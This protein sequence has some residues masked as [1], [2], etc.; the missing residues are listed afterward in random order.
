MRG[1][2][3]WPRRLCGGAFRFVPYL[4]PRA[5][6]EDSGIPTITGIMTLRHRLLLQFLLVLSLPRIASSDPGIAVRGLVLDAKTRE[7]LP[8]AS[9][10]VLGSSRGT[11]A[12]ADGRFVLALDADRASLAVSALGY[13]PD[14]VAV[15]GPRADLTVAL[16]PA[17]IVMPEVVVTSEDPAYEIV[18][19]AIAARKRWAERLVTYRMAAF[20]R[21]T[22]Y[23]DTAVASITESYTTGYWQRG[24]TLREVVRQRRQ[25]ENLKADVNVARVGRILNFAED[26]VRFAGYRFTGPVAGDALD[27]YRYRLLRTRTAYGGEVHDIAMTPRSRTAALFE[28]T[29]SIAGGTYA[30]VGVD[31]A[32][33]DAFQIPF[34]KEKRLR[35]RQQFSL[36]DSLY[37]MPADIHIDA[38]FSIGALAFTFPRIRF[39]QTSVIT[40]YAVNVPLPDSVFRRPVF[41]VD[42]AAVRYDSTFWA[43]NEVLPLSAEEERAYRELDSTKTLDV[44]FRPGGVAVTLGFGGE[45]AGTAV[46]VLDYVDAGFNRVEGFRLGGKFDRVFGKPGADSSAAFGVN[47]GLAYGFS[48]RLWKYR[49][50]FTLFPPGSARLSV[51]GDVYRRVPTTPDFGYYGGLFNSLTALFFKND[52]HDYYRTEGWR[53]FA[54]AKP[55][56]TLELEAGFRVEEHRAVAQNTDYSFFNRSR[57]YRPLPAARE[58]RLH[59]IDLRLRV[60]AARVPLDL[61]TGDYLS[62]RLEVADAGGLGGDFTYAAAKAEGMLV[63]PT[64]GRSL[65]LPAQL[66]IRAMAGV[67]GAAGGLP[68]QH[69]FAVESA[70][71][72][73]GPFGVMRGMGVKEYRG[74]DMLA[75]ALEHNFRSLPFLALDIPFLYE[76]SVEFLVHGGVARVWQDAWWSAAAPV[77][78][79]PDGWYAEAG[80]GVGRLFDLFR[81]DATWRIRP[82]GLLRVTV[83]TGSIL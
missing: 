2:G 82:G 44:Q 1:G 13:A 63:L 21:Q 37:W 36:V 64:F 68:P 24:D 30:L 76:R 72:G 83:A 67:S 59:A 46:S 16:E 49:A 79:A 58:G 50:G 39:V 35:Y 9:V 55:V 7:P 54:G 18:R 75:V 11:V 78:P 47:A 6:R 25:T 23:R 20:T 32:P 43:E 53:L 71:S 8:A 74:T 56:G 17:E 15:A 77:P 80:F 10:R 66:R 19:R 65:L 41:T 12:N 26:E 73:V 52:Y 51:G 3:G 48:D 31:V 60:G 62:L 34:V 5:F 69:L 40:D 45:G 81:I 33:N 28:G 42:S 29:I 38:D 57:E 22:L 61:V 4:P 70:S 27:N 14:T